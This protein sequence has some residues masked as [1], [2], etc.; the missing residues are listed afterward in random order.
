MSLKSRVSPSETIHLVT[1]QRAADGQEADGTP[2]ETFSSYARV[3]ASITP[4]SGREYFSASGRQA[5]VTHQ[6]R[7][8]YI[9]GVMPKWR[10]TWQGR[11][12]RIVSVLELGRRAGLELMCAEIV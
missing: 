11:T 3:G 1:I 5:E 2:T 4:V 12:F 9:T 6:I 8:H 7:T 10:I